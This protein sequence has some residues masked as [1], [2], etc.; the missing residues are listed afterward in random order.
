MCSFDLINQRLPRIENTSRIWRILSIAGLL[1]LLLVFPDDNVFAK[2]LNRDSSQLN[3]S[4]YFDSREYNTLNIQ[5]STHKLPLDIFFWGFIDIHSEQNNNSDRFDLSRYFIEYRFIR[6]VGFGIEGL[7][8][9]AEYNDFNG[10]NNSL[11]RFGVTYKHSLP[12]LGGSKSWLQWRIH[13]LDTGSSGYQASVIFTFWL[14]KGIYISG[15]A[16]LNL[17]GGQPHRWVA[18]PQLNF[19]LNEDFD[20]IVE[21]RINEVEGANPSQS[22]SGVALGVKVKF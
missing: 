10:S 9:E 1:F 15:F 20:L 18:E 13:P 22:G 4:Y 7:N 17:D 2:D 6:P 21:G 16:D 12:F 11:V 14:A 5:A 3:V 19:V 8:W